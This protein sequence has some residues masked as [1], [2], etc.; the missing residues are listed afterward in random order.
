MYLH[1][2][3]RWRLLK[4]QSRAQCSYMVIH[5]KICE[6]GLEMLQL[7]LN[8]GPVCDDSGAEGSICANVALYKWTL[9]SP[10]QILFC[11]SPDRR[12]GRCRHHWRC[13]CPPSRG[14]SPTHA[15]SAPGDEPTPSLLS[16]NSP[17]ASATVSSG[18]C[19]TAWCSS[20]ESKPCRSIT[21][22]PTQ[23]HMRVDF[24][25]QT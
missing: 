12:Q 3:R 1:G 24:S 19:L 14:W 13:H 18:S 20:P 6:R 22:H 10:Y 9:P 8:A 2:S 15:A 4:P 23:Q 17:S 11:S 25:R 5:V 21:W 16:R 7:R